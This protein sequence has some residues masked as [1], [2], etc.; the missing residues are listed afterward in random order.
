V[1]L[2]SRHARQKILDVGVDVHHGWVCVMAFLIHAFY[3]FTLGA[4]GLVIGWNLEVWIKAKR[5]LSA[6]LSS[7]ANGEVRTL[8]PPNMIH[9]GDV[10]HK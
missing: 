2:T 4:M 1:R 6:C 9:S 10:R 5:I 3:S 7:T 8:M